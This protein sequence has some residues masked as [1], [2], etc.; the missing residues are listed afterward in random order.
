MPKY[1][2]DPEVRA[3][4]LRLRQE[5]KLTNKGLAQTLLIEG[6]NETF[7][8]KYAHD[9]L[10]RQVENF[11]ARFRDTVK[12]LRERIA[13]GSEIFETSVTRRLRNGLDLVRRTGDIAL[14]TSQAG[15]G[16][17]SGIRAYCRDNPSAVSITLN[18]TTR[19]ANKVESLVFATIDGATWKSN[20]PRFDYLTARFKEVSRLL[21]VDNAQRLDGTGRQWLFDFHDLA[22]CPIALIGNPDIGFLGRITGNDQ[23]SSRI[24]ISNS[25][26]LDADEIPA[27][28]KLVAAQFSDRSTAAAIEDLVA[29]IASHDGRLRAVK[30]AVILA[31]ELR[32]ASPK[33]KDD[34]RAALRAAHSRLVRDYALPAD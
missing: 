7:L 14:F 15:N 26:E 25:Y 34:P 28:A 5:L 3:E 10:D 1:P 22:N 9:N 4:I 33:L 31:Q 20:S 23:Q 29:I 18:A 17:T 27:A 13:F 12:S 2:T 16:K 21:I 8:S 19:C 32:K 11:E 6:V 24:G 30:K